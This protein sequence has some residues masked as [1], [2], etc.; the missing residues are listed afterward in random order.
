MYNFTSCYNHSIVDNYEKLFVDYK[1][2]LI[3]VISEKPNEPLLPL[4]DKLNYLCLKKGRQGLLTNYGEGLTIVEISQL[5]VDKNDVPLACEATITSFENETKNIRFYSYKLMDKKYYSKSFSDEF[6][7]K[8]GWLTKN[9]KGE[10]ELGKE[11]YKGIIFLNNIFKTSSWDYLNSIFENIRKLE[12]A[13]HK[14][15]EVINLI[16]LLKSKK[17]LTPE[18][19]ENF[20]IAIS[21]DKFGAL[22]TSIDGANVSEAIIAEILTASLNKSKEI[23]AE[24]EYWQKQFCFFNSIPYEKKIMARENLEETKS[25]L[26]T[27]SVVEAEYFKSREIFIA[28]YNECQNTAVKLVIAKN[29]F[30]V[31]ENDDQIS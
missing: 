15:K 11:I 1:I 30:K 4:F 9:S 7:K 23:I 25:F 27:F 22:V 20:G 31:G 19:I 14:N 10:F 17:K 5:Y 12:I 3:K 16:Y 8:L 29:F 21:A 28:E 13:N 24:L 6:L 26:Q 2:N 18:Q